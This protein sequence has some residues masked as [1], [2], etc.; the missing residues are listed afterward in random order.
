MYWNEQ[1]ITNAIPGVEI[2]QDCY[3]K[4]V[5]VSINTKTLQK[6]DVFIALPGKKTDGHNFIAEAFRK[7]ASGII[8]NKAQEDCLKDIA[9]KERAKK[10]ILLVDN[11]RQALISL[12]AAWRQRFD[13]PVFCITG[14]V[15]KTSTKQLLLCILDR[16]GMPYAATH[17]SENTI[18]GLALSIFAMNQ[19]HKLAV[20]ELGI[21]KRGEMEQLVALAQP[22]KALITCI[23]HSHM[24]GL[25]SMSDIATEKRK[26]FSLF[27]E[28]N[29]GIVNGDQ[30]L[31]AQ[32][33]Y[34]HPVIKFGIKTTNQIQARKIVSK[35]SSIHFVLKVYG[36]KYPIVLQTSHSGSI[37]NVLAAISAAYLFDIPIETIVQAIQKPLI[38]AGRFEKKSLKKW[39]GAIINDCFNASP[40]SMKEALLAFERLK[41][42]GPKIA[43]LGDML[44]LGVNSSFWHRQLGRFLRKGTSLYRLILVGEH[45]TLTKK[46]VPVN[47]EVQHVE[48][49]QAAK[50]LVEEHLVDDSLI[51]VKGSRALHLE[52]LV[53]TLS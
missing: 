38:V 36:K 49:W 37:Q 7:G 8:I 50:K 52:N 3:P 43:V 18:I 5:T 20:F 21:S 11:T 41:P 27:A 9:Q 31:L 23:G 1:F 24:E 2:R 19:N 35:E 12:A 42:S 16:H 10:L 39:K 51:L 13:Y 25:G 6:G 17:G 45:V 48:N 47:V 29:I 22:T 30:P 32:V 15:G 44:E 4:A 46:T 28:D 53:E 40:E 33:G 34:P 14:S 26:V